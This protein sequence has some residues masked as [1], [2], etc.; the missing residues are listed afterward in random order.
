[1]WRTAAVLAC[2]AGTARADGDVAAEVAHARGLR[3]KQPVPIETLA[4]DA[5]AA[6]LAARD[7]GDDALALVRWGLAAPGDALAAPRLTAFYDAA[8]KSVVVLAGAPDLA[9]VPALE[10]ALLDQV[11][12]PAFDAAG[13]PDGDARRARRALEDGDA[14]ALSIEIALARAGTPPPWDDPELAA[15]LVA[16]AGAAVDPAAPLALREAERFSYRDGLAF[17]AALRRGHG[18]RAVDA[19]FRRP[20]T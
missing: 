11:F 13:P 15:G 20:P 12:G 17:V 6:R 5:F 7:P 10:H 9:L 18:W 3:F 2:L 4:A 1:M 16:A 14:V 8:A 19:A